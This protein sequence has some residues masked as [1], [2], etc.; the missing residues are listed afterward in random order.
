MIIQ[1]FIYLFCNLRINITDEDSHKKTN[2]DNVDLSCDSHN[3]TYSVLSDTSTF[4]IPNGTSEKKKK[5]NTIKRSK[6]LRL[7]RDTEYNK[8]SVYDVVVVYFNYSI[9]L[10][11]PLY[12]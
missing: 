5:P 6:S 10:Y 12:N 4:G 3:S 11:I 7:K 9:F 8:F 2:E 1:Y